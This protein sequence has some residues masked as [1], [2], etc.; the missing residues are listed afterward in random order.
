M[1]TYGEITHIP[2]L[3]MHV[4]AHVHKYTRESIALP[5]S[6]GGTGEERNSH[7]VT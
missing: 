3:A 5:C 7:A 4:F 2:I 1:P 6:S